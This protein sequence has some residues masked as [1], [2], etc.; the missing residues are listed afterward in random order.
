MDD[1]ALAAKTVELARDSGIRSGFANSLAEAPWKPQASVG[2]TYCRLS[3]GARGSAANGSWPIFGRPESGLHPEPSP[4]IRTYVWKPQ[5]Y[6]HMESSY[7]NAMPWRY[8]LR[9]PYERRK[10]V[11]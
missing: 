3:G 9:K 6:T 1:S 7:K 5:Q 2:I 4:W 11:H 8:V 10:S